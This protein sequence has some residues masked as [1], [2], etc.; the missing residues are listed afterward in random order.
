MKKTILLL[1]LL[2][3]F[4]LAACGGGGDD[5][6][7]SSAEPQSFNLAWEFTNEFSYDPEKVGVP[8][9]STVT[10]DLDN[11]GASVAHSWV[12]VKAGAITDSAT[13][14]EIDAAAITERA[15]SGEIV[16]G[17][18]KQ[19]TFRAPAEAGD[20]EFICSVAGH[21]VGGMRGEFAVTQ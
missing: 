5:G 8:A 15:N 4:A 2:L 11:S 18:K 10:V 6:G 13:P 7:S 12:L 19:I 1:S 16:A 20:Y 17:E 3:T 14:E 21:L 9:G